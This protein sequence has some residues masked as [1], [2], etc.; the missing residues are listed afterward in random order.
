M[1]IDGNVRHFYSGGESRMNPSEGIGIVREAMFRAAMAARNL[2]PARSLQAFGRTE[3]K[4]ESVLV[5]NLDRQPARWR[6]IRRELNR[7]R[8]HDGESLVELAL[9]MP[10]ID[11]RDS[12]ETA[13]TAD[14]DPIYP[15]ADHLFVQPDPRLEE[16]F[17]ADELIR[18]TRQ[19]IAVARSHIEAWKHIANGPQRHVLVLEDDVYFVRGAASLIDR[20]WRAAGKGRNTPD[21]PQLL[22]LSYKDAGGTA[23]RADVSADLFR[24]VRGFWYLSGYVLSRS[25][26]ASL[27]RSMPVVGPVDLWMN[28]RFA[29]LD[30]LALARPALLQRLDGGSDNAYSIL[31]YLS[32]AGAVDAGPGP[33]L[34]TQRVGGLVFA[35]NTRGATDVMGMALSMLGHRV[36]SCRNDVLASDLCAITDGD[37][38]LF[39]AYVDANLDQETVSAILEQRSDAR[40]VVMTAELSGGLAVA[41]GDSADR[42]LPPDRT[43]VLRSDGAGARRWEPLCGFLGL[44]IPDIAFPIGADHAVGLFRVDNLRKEDK[45]A[46]VAR[47]PAQDESPWVLSQS[48]NWRPRRVSAAMQARSAMAETIIHADL[49]APCSSFR[50]LTET[51]PGNLATF[52]PRGAEH[53]PDGITLVLSDCPGSVRQFRSGAFASVDCFTYGRF[54]AEI[55]AAHGPGLV[56]GFF[57]HRDSPRQE[58]DIELLGC[59]PHRMLVNVYFNPGDEGAALAYGYR[60]TPHLVDLGFDASLDFHAYAIEWMPACVRWLVD[61]CIVHERLRWD[62]TPIPHLPMRSHANL[63]APRS[64]ELAGPLREAS[65]P[66]KSVFRNMSVQ[67]LCEPSA[68]HRRSHAA[69]P[70]C[71]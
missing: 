12:R 52:D 28:R 62:P 39:D 7:F 22:Y 42:S 38:L 17:G 69:L 70:S 54:E 2:L 47:V 60:G 15:M 36:R 48:A 18:M 67:A 26:A 21:R 64:I 34:P 66:A 32:R 24:P 65:L 31:P 13:P 27:L 1:W 20:G 11:A 23:Q 68:T 57:L 63:W 59:D 50:T 6:R 8:A 56:T 14:V 5:I 55:K 46:E 71:P 29:E 10:A 45:N 44:G 41:G 49:S 16:C 19:E 4:V 43:L 51:F 33:V 30:V 40:F 9:R 35:W 25:G 53:G 58:I 37:E 3:G 61:G